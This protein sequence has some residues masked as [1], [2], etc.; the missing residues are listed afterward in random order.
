MNMVVRKECGLMML[1]M[2]TPRALRVGQRRGFARAY[3]D[4]YSTVGGS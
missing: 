1:V 2:T 4:T 3:L